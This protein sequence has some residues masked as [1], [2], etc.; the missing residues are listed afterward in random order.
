MIGQTISHYR[1]VEKLGGGGMGV[2]YK[3]EDTRLHRFVALKFLPEEV[4]RDP[5][6]L[7]RFQREAQSAS[8]LNHP[9]IC[10]IYDIVEQDGQSFIV[11]EFLDGV[12]LKYR[13]SG[14][15][16]DMEVLLAI[17]IDIADALDAAHAAGV[18]H[19]DIKPT[20]IFVTKRGHAKIL[21][22]GLAK[23]SLAAS[24]L[25]KIASLAT[26][27]GSLDAEHL[28]SPG[29]MLGTVAYMSPEQVRA[30]E[31]DA[32]TDLF[33]FG[34]VL[35]EM[36][37]GDLPF[38]GE[39][40]VMVCEAIVN[41]APVAVVRLNHDVPPKLEDIINKALEKDRELRYQ[42]A[43]EMRAD[44]KRLKRETESGKAAAETSPE[45]VG[46]TASGGLAEQ[47]GPRQG[48]ASSSSVLIAEAR[49]HKGA[50][51]GTAVVVLLLVIAAAFGL[52][53]L[54]GRHAPAIDTRNIS[55]R[56][57]TDHGQAVGNASI[58]ADGRLLAYARQEGE[59]SLRVK[60]IVTGSEVTV[61]PPQTGMFG[62][63]TFTPDGNYLYYQHTDP[64]N[65]NKTNL[66]SVPSLGG[67][68]R[69]VVSDVG[70]GMAFSPDGKRMVFA[71]SVPA[72]PDK[73]EDQLVIAN[74]DGSG[75]N[76][77]LRHESNLRGISTDPSW[78][79]SGEL[80]AV[81][82]YGFG[83][84]NALG[85]I[86]VLT[87]G[88]KLVKSFPLPMFIN[89]VAWLPDSSGLLFTGSEKSIISRTQVWFLPYPAG[90]PF[91]VS[92]DLSQYSALS[93][94]ADGRSFVTTQKR[95]QAAIYV[96]DSPAVL[97]DKIDWKLTPISAEQ[98]TGYSLSWT[99]A[100]KLLQMDSASHA[101]V[102]G[103]EGSNRVRLLENDP[104]V[105]WPTACGPGDV[106]VLSMMSEDNVTQVWRL[107]VATGELKQLTF[108]Q[109]DWGASCTPDGKWV[110]YAETTDAFHI[111]KISID[112]GTPVELA[113]PAWGPMVSP[114]GKLLAYFRTDGQG[115]SAKTK[116]VVQKLDGGAPI[117]EIELSPIYNADKLD[118]T[119]DGHGLTYVHNTTGHT[120]NVYMQPLAG[121]PPVQLT[122]FDSEPGRVA[123]YAWSR[124][125]KKFAITRARRN[126]SDVVMFS[127]FR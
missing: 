51:L 55:I 57:L 43:S 117:Q 86:L 88:G 40:S 49:R 71:R 21:D 34:A 6:A 48:Q 68:S 78:S 44:L 119:P 15:P 90:E 67:A 33:S 84:K 77:I 42:H 27:T 16:L 5:Q 127:G 116:F 10:T 91:K 25:S 28:T 104:V 122:H 121:G 61:V 56:P 29:T 96:G 72:T 60:Q 73:P 111:F 97:S 69:Q 11:M 82:V 75:E 4:A 23:V 123:A 89:D 100:G 39:S 118:W 83:N 17:A 70:S 106:V 81:G 66:Y 13:I 2:V 80:I 36:A 87:P 20:N 113:H 38:H 93:V 30:K 114:D 26:Q 103:S 41:R 102:T 99:A 58:S 45:Q 92:N 52:Y 65:P 124:D 62:S 110:L 35:Y 22:F 47:S 59:R 18:V 76:I 24:S 85:S 8:A 94:T 32:R 126:D 98:A 74:A 46:T 37:T 54:L 12:T 63:A 105:G 120:Q 125:G 9:N 112:G 79:A 3:A 1:I 14:R 95:P 107:N 64:A 7:A 101:Y 19:R 109:L 31:L 108:G 115:T 53:K 50:L